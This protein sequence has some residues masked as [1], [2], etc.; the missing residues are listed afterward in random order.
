MFLDVVLVSLHGDLCNVSVQYYN[1]SGENVQ[2]N[3][4]GIRLSINEDFVLLSCGTHTYLLDDKTAQ[5]SS[6]HI[7]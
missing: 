3:D 6:N 1:G 7:L 5:Y 2:Y 4:R